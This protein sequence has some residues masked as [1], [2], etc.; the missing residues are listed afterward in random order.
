M[1]KDRLIKTVDDLDDNWI[2]NGYC[3]QHEK[4]QRTAEKQKDGKFKIY[5]S[6]WEREI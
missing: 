2:W 1:N 4:T 5:C 3:W 6:D